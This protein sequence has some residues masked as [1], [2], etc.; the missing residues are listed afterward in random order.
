MVVILEKASRLS[1]TKTR[2]NGQNYRFGYVIYFNS[3]L[4]FAQCS[5]EYSVHMISQEETDIK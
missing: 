2:K 5:L 4:I 1:G 3:N